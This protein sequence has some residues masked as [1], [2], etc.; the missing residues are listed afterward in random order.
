MKTI[1]FKIS[2][3][4]KAVYL[5]YTP[6]SD[7]LVSS[8]QTDKGIGIPD[9]VLAKLGINFDKNSKLI[10][11]KSIKS[12]PK[13]LSNL[14]NY[15]YNKNGFSLC[16]K[17]TFHF[18]Q[19]DIVANESSADTLTFNFI[20][21]CKKNNL[22]YFTIEG[23]KLDIGT[24]VD[25]VTSDKKD[26]KFTVDL[27]CTGYERRTSI[28]KK[29]SNLINDK[30]I[31]IFSDKLLKKFANKEG[32]IS[33]SDYENL[34]NNFPT[35]TVLQHYGEEIVADQLGEQFSFKKD[36]NKQFLKSKKIVMQKNDNVFSPTGDA[37]INKNIVKN[38]HQSVIRLKSSLEKG[39]RA[40]DENY[41][42]KLILN[43][44]PVLYPQYVGFIREAKIPE[45]FSKNGK[46]TNRS[47]DDAL[48]DINGNIDILEVKCPFPKNHLIMKTKYRDNW[49]P[50]RELSGGIIQLQKYIYY[51]DHLGSEKTEE[52][53]QKI[54]EKILEDGN[55][56]LNSNFK[57][58]FNNPRALLLIGY[59]NSQDAFTES[60]KRDFEVIR[61][62]YNNIIDIITYNDLLDRLERTIEFKTNNLM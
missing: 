38:L 14:P 19:S 28:F 39:Y 58:Q 18:R 5:V 33:I 54:K 23:R 57:L 43:I 32:T 60:E 61:R 15:N 7:A 47:L 9:V 44:L 31:T 27:F 3:D 35:T 49:I 53:T 21:I 34:I 50:A 11:Y 26:I 41:W 30:T 36:Y 59:T 46:E 12:M 1:N 51:I 8:R 37:T 10:K 20:N 29:I 56:Q 22:R 25:F 4:K 16:L 52:V 6:Q 48:I 40:Y 55:M 13:Y 2:K 62:Q 45:K 24:N 17:K 42:Q